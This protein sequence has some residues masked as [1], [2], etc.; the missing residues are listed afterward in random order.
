MQPIDKV[1][2]KCQKILGQ[3]PTYS[4]YKILESGSKKTKIN[5]NN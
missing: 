5:K 4:E 1:A 2:I 3:T